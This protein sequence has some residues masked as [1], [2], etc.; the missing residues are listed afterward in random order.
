[1]EDDGESESVHARIGPLGSIHSDGDAQRRRAFLKVAADYSFLSE[2]YLQALTECVL[3]DQVCGPCG[4]VHCFDWKHLIKR[5]RERLKSETTGV[6]ISDGPAITGPSLRRLA[7]A[8]DPQRR[9]E[10]LFN[11]ADR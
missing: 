10:S 2:D 6:K 7:V 5:L 11:P 8:L 1:M 4:V 9:L 3:M